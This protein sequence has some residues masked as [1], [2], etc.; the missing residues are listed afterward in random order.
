MS[1]EDRQSEIDFASVSGPW[2]TDPNAT[3]ADQLKKQSA[4]WPVSPDTRWLLR[5]NVNTLTLRPASAPTAGEIRAIALVGQANFSD[6]VLS[7]MAGNETDAT[8]TAYGHPDEFLASAD[9]EMGGAERRAAGA[10]VL[11]S[12]RSPTRLDRHEDRGRRGRQGHAE[13]AL[14]MRST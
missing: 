7:D 5:T 11:V 6:F 14:C 10:L 13:R 4:F 12:E 1:A 8:R 3:E 9:R 2:S